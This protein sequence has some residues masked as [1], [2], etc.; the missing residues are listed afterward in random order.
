MS[1]A[2]VVQPQGG[3]G[4]FFNFSPSF[5]VGLDY[6]YTRMLREQFDNT[7]T[8]LRGGGVAG[9]V[10]RDLKLSFHGVTALAEFNVL[11]AAGGPLS[12]YVGAG[13]GCLFAAGYAYTIEVR[14][15]VR[16]DGM[17]NKISISGHNEAQRYVTPCIPATLSLEYAFLPQVAVSFGG[18]YRFLLA[19]GN[20]FAPKGQAYATLGLRFNLSK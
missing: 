5:R 11:G 8:Q 3:A 10:F 1:P 12:L 2:T 6:S 17:G 9:E 4:L 16:A 19:R 7:L 20:E 13:A 18:G 15:E 14:D